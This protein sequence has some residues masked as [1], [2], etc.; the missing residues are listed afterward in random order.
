VL[1][2]GRCAPAVDARCDPPSDR[3]AESQSRKSP[4]PETLR[5]AVL[6]LSELSEANVSLQFGWGLPPDHTS[7]IGLPASDREIRSVLWFHYEW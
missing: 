3:L 4:M 1:F 2:L 7:S 5:L 6:A